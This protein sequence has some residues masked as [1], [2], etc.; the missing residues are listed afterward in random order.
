MAKPY[1]EISAN[2]LTFMAGDCD[3]RIIFNDIIR[4]SYISLTH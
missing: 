2:I 1:I 3:G 4:Y